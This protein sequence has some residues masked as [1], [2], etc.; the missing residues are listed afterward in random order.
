MLRCSNWAVPCWVSKRRA[1]S[2]A[3]AISS[4]EAA[5][6]ARSAADQACARWY[7]TL[8]PP[9]SAGVRSGSAA[10]ARIFWSCRSVATAASGWPSVVNTGT[11]AR[12]VTTS[13]SGESSG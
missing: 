7:P 12:A 13:G 8:S 6:S 11:P 5:R 4:A 10:S 9:R 3:C 2:P 1:R